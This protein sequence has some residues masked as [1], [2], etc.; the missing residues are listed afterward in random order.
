MLHLLPPEIHLSGNRGACLGKVSLR[1]L[2]QCAIRYFR[3]TTLSVLL[4]LLLQAVTDT[5]GSKSCTKWPT[6]HL[7]TAHVP[8][9]DSLRPLLCTAMDCAA[10]TGDRSCLLIWTRHKAPGKQESVAS[11]EPLLFSFHLIPGLILF[12]WNTKPRNR[13]LRCDVKPYNCK[14]VQ[15]YSPSDHWDC[16]R[17]KSV[18]QNLASNTES[19]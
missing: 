8:H 4:Q 10:G 19:K 14:T 12:S 11:W 16:M 7:P 3:N 15:P 2:E 9:F 17:S 13:F 18:Y 5:G 1:L 6:A